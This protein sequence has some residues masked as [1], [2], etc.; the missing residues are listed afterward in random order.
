MPAKIL[1]IPNF[2]IIARTPVSPWLSACFSLKPD[3][4]S[5]AAVAKMRREK[6]GE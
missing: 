5:L 2:W 1:N 6:I 3:K 4:Q